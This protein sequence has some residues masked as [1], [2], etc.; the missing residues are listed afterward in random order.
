MFGLEVLLWDIEDNSRGILKMLKSYY[1][2]DRTGHAAIQLTLPVNPET[3]QWI[4][5]YCYRHNAFAPFI[6][7]VKTTTKTTNDQGFESQEPC[8]QV[9]FSWWPRGLHDRFSDELTQD[10]DFDLSKIEQ[11]FTKSYEDTIAHKKK[12]IIDL[13]EG[14][15]QHAMDADLLSKIKRKYEKLMTLEYEYQQQLPVGQAPDQTFYFPITRQHSDFGLNAKEILK[16]MHEFVTNYEF[17]LTWLNCSHAVRYTLLSGILPNSTLSQQLGSWQQCPA[18]FDNPSFLSQFCLTLEITQTK[19]KQ[20]CSK[21]L[22]FSH[23]SHE[24]ASDKKTPDEITYASFRN[25]PKAKL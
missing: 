22:L 5:T 8:Y 20:Q 17:N 12:R 2:Y 24:G 15:P 14:A 19:L 9:Y 21:P 6:P 25:K 18:I 13:L 7:F 16:Y 4:Q 10:K 23:Q 11:L 3:Q 1:G